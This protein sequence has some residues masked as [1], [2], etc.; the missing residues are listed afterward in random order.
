MRTPVPLSVQEM[1][2]GTR[3]QRPFGMPRRLLLLDLDPFA[4]PPAPRITP[5]L[6]LPLPDS[7][8]AIP[9]GDEP[10]EGV[11]ASLLLEGIPIRSSRLIEGN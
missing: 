9:L 8:V 3:L 10:V 11:L 1:L 5:Q 7:R 6:L 2:R 4:P